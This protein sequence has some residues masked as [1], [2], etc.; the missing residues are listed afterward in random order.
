[1][2]TLLVGAALLLASCASPPESPCRPVGG[3][4]KLVKQA[5]GTVAIQASAPSFE[6]AT[7]VLEKSP[8]DGVTMNGVSGGS[9]SYLIFDF[10]RAGTGRP[11]KSGKADK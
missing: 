5:D 9:Q 11:E 8:H 10:P 2:K 1:M 6:C 7:Y 4:G 3:G